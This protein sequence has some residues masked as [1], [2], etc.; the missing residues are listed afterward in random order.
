MES[1]PSSILAYR[2]DEIPKNPVGKIDKPTLRA[3]L[4]TTV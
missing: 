4:T 1:G 3:G 2:V